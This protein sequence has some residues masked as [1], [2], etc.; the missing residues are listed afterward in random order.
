VYENI[1]KK[2]LNFFRGLVFFYSGFL[3]VKFVSIC[4]KNVLDLFIY[5]P[6][7]S[8]H[9]KSMCSISQDCSKQENGEPFC[10]IEHRVEGFLNTKRR[11]SCN[12]SSNQA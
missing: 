11:N 1:K 4:F 9:I 2:F 12:S 3:G 7:G 6:K 8:T 5:V 10:Y